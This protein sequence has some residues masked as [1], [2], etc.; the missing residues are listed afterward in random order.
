VTV[1]QDPGGF[2]DDGPRDAQRHHERVRRQVAERLRER[3]GEE[4]LIT[5]GPEHRIRIPVKGSKEY[6]F[7]FDRGAGGGAGQGEAQP[8]D[9]I[10]PGPGPESGDPAAPGTEP[11][12]EEYEVWLD[13][14]EV[15]QLLF[16]QLGLPRLRPK[17]QVQETVSIVFDDLAR[18]GTLLDKKET[19]RANMLRNAA[20]GRVRM[21]GFE[22]DDLRYQTYRERERPKT[23]AVVFMLMDVSGSM[24]AFEKRC[25]RLF[26]WW[27]TRFLRSRYADVQLV[28]IAHHT[29][30][31]E[32]TEDEF[33][34][35]VESGGTRVSS[36]LDLC[37]ELG[38]RRYPPSDWDWIC[39]IA[40]DGDNE[41]ADNA[42]V[43]DLVGAVAAKAV[44]VAY[45][46][47]DRHQR[48]H[49]G[50]QHLFGVISQLS[51]ANLVTTRV[52]RDDE[53][54]GALK[55]VYRPG[56]DVL[57]ESA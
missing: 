57:Q 2:H 1:V 11:G 28:F 34:T 5:A 50:G 52:R 12:S 4:K 55:E 56:D 13:R 15:E 9:Q 20:S 53:I 23:Q 48:F 26:F 45:M 54:W 51:L 7:I 46:Q 30:A 18:K 32:C 22:R 6:R 44:L 49:W 47:I 19:V 14:D 27:A 8:G 40:S 41:A 39:L 29:E 3:I 16:E 21:G 24:G 25:A 37:L 43:L 38:G 35:R 17:A 10:E 33:F 42:R 31:R 36:A